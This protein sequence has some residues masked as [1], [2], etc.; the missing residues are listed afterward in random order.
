MFNRLLKLPLNG[1]SSIF[2]FGPRGTGKTSWLKI[3]LQDYIYLD[4]LDYSIYSS[5]VANP[6]RLDAMIPKDYDKWVIIDE[7]QRV[8]ELLNE[9]HRL[10]EGRK[11]K[12]ILTGSSAKGSQFACRKSPKIPYAPACN[13]RSRRKLQNGKRSYLRASS[14]DILRR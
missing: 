7:V 11:I 10:I 4:L 2:L 5:L 14:K 9:V 1:N 3:N 6:N 12:F 8:P 13:S